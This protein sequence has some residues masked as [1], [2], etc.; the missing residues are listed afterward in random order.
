MGDAD[1]ADDDDD[2][3]SGFYQLHTPVRTACSTLN[4][5]LT[6]EPTTYLTIY[7]A[8]NYLANRSDVPESC[9]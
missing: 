7:S 8:T 9:V 1:V 3:A 2:A 6:T 5:S 4:G